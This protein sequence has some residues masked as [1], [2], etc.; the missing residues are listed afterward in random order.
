[1]SLTFASA[2]ARRSLRRPRP[3]CVSPPLRPVLACTVARN[4][5]SCGVCSRLVTHRG[6]VVGVR[7]FTSRA[8]GTT[9]CGEPCRRDA[10]FKLPDAGCTVATA[11]EVATGYMEAQAVPEPGL[12]AQ[13]LMASAL[14]AALPGESAV[15]AAGAAA[16]AVPATLATVQAHGDRAMDDALMQKFCHLIQ[17]RA[18]ER[19][20]IQVRAHALS[21]VLPLSCPADS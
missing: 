2:V 12:S 7:T 3:T 21:L 5:S 17:R 14:A 19:V 8:A 16:P 20:P 18:S 11:V 10:T 4:P 15:D 9:G 1:M 6:R 13:Y